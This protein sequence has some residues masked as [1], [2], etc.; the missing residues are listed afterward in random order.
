MSELSS[1]LLG[2]MLFWVRFLLPGL[3][4]HW[5]LPRPPEP[6]PSRWLKLLVSGW[7][8]SWLGL[9][10]SLTVTLVLA[11]TGW[12]VRPVDWILLLSVS[13][14]G[15]LVRR[16]VR[17]PGSGPRTL[18]SPVASVLLALIFAGILLVP[19]RGEWMLG[20][21]DPGVY[22][23]EGLFVARTGTFHPPPEQVLQE[24]SS[25]E[26]SAFMR[27]FGPSHELF[28]AVPVDL[29]TRRYDLFFF[30]LMPC[31]VAAF[32]RCGGLA[33]ALRVNHVLALFAWLAFGAAAW[34]L[35]RSGAVTALSLLLLAAQPLWLYHTHVPISELLQG[36]LFFSM[37]AGALL[38]G[39]GRARA[40]LLAWLAFLGLVNRFSFLPWVG[41]WLGVLAWLDLDREDRAGVLGEHALV[42]AG[43]AAGVLYDRAFCAVTLGRI[44]DVWSSVKVVAAGC[45]GAAFALDALAFSGPLRSRL[46]RMRPPLLLAALAAGIAGFAALT[47][48]A[49]RGVHPAFLSF[50]KP[51]VW[52][53]GWPFT[54]LALLGLAAVLGT[55]PPRRVPIVLFALFGVGTLAYIAW[56]PNAV[57]IFPYAAR[58]F[59]EFTLPAMAF[60]SALVLGRLWEAR[61]SWTRALAAA[62]VAVALASAAQKDARAWRTTAYDGVGPV[63]EDIAARIAPT[64]VLVADHF[65]WGTP[66]ALVHGKQVLNGE[67]LWAKRAEKEPQEVRTGLAAVK[68]LKERGYRIL[69]LTSTP[70]GLSVYPPGVFSAREIW[71]RPPFSVREVVH[72]KNIRGFEWHTREA[73][74]RLYE[75]DSVTPSAGIL[76]G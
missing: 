37:W 61:G 12:F 31:A 70:E 20:G 4:W 46:V 56:A 73:V 19:H 15:L 45:F 66:L 22:M 13:A 62:L 44:A 67:R 75:L 6:L 34:G 59:L 60:L 54:V 72:G 24:L 7:A 10:I 3:A 68:K 74:F 27:H 48:A 39:K 30:R 64:D 28:P 18:Y 43:V 8:V 65:W 32:E 2:G 69:L 21:W 51:L 47:W 53:S 29:E 40:A 1:A 58:R 5:V 17:R 41:L 9:A 36:C 49:A 57:T 63:L 14:L 76:S 33:G 11:E 25:D 26:L 52:F 38:W 42:M 23:N 50:V 16:L 55:A 35:S 71:V